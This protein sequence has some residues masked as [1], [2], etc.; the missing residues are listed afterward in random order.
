MKKILIFFSFIVIS[1]DPIDDRLSINNTTS[2]TLVVRMMF[3]SEL[4]NKPMHWNR[5]REIKLLPSKEN[6]IGIFNK[7]E[8]EFKRALPDTLINIIVV[9]NYDFDN[10]QKKWDSIYGSKSYYL[11]KVSLKDIKSKNWFLEYPNDGFS[12]PFPN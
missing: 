8:G 6:K 5:S 4:P 2:D 12:L 10:N 7:W 3:D 1:C 11:K 9:R